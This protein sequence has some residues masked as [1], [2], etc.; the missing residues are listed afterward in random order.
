MCLLRLCGKKVADC[1]I[2]KAQGRIKNL[3]PFA[4]KKRGRFI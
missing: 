1:F 3:A 2:A 4:V